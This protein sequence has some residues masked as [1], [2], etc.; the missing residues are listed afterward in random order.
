MWQKFDML[1]MYAAYDTFALSSLYESLCSIDGMARGSGLSAQFSMWARE[2]GVTG[3]E[4]VPPDRRLGRV[5]E[6][7]LWARDEEWQGARSCG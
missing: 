7:H 3:G 6:R 2:V 4:R 5:G 1:D